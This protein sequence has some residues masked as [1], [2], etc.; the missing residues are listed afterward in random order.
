MWSRIA[1][2]SSLQILL[3]FVVV[4]FLIRFPFFFRDYVDHDESTFILMGQALVDGYLPYIKYWDLKPP[5]VFYFFAGIIAVFGKSMIAIR[6]AGSL[7]V[8]LTAFYSYKLSRTY[9]DKIASFFVGLLTIYLLSLFGAMQGVMSEHLAALPLV[10]GLI[11]LTKKHTTKNL[12]LAGFLFG[13]AIDFRLNLAYVIFFVNAFVCLHAGLNKSGIKKGVFLSIGSILAI[14]LSLLPYILTDQLALI[15]TSVIDA[16][17]AYSAASKQ[18]LKTL[19]FILVV[20]LLCGLAYKFIRPKEIRFNFYLLLS[21][22]FGQAIM[23][24]ISGK[25]N[26]HYLIQVFPFLLIIFVGLI[27]KFPFPKK[28]NKIAPKL[29]IALFILLPMESY[30][31]IAT[32]LDSKNK[33]DRLFNGEGYNTAH[34]L[35]EHY[36]TELPKNSFYL[37]EHIGYWILNTMPPTA[38]TMH[39]SNLVRETTFE[40]IQNIQKDPLSELKYILE[41]KK[42]NFI[43]VDEDRN[44]LRGDSI[45]FDY[46]KNSLEKY[47][48]LEKEF[49][50]DKSVKIYKRKSMLFNRPIF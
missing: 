14:I 31:E 4:A 36:G 46:Y 41:V 24:L 47:F 22:L 8:A 42:P 27:S 13:L 5:M 21:M 25:V 15:K 6:A 43:I 35:M 30:L 23:F 17:I 18:T 37:N 49:T 1:K 12:I 11:Y 28:F 39:P 9:L 34:Y 48:T 40:H 16:S 32:V 33:Y 44:Q 20:A 26:G 3:L 19:P 29:I 50:P 2:L 38:I 45:V 7:V 10:V